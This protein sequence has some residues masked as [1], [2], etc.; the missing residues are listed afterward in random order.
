MHQQIVKRIVLICM[1]FCPGA[2]AS[3]PQS[4]GASNED[5]EFKK[6][7]LRGIV[8]FVT[9][10][11]ANSLLASTHISIARQVYILLLRQSVARL[12]VQ[13]SPSVVTASQPTS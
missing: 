1:I 6:V 9:N 3:K 11:L 4:E 8:D 2:L 5:I 13:K 7:E 10:I 12:V